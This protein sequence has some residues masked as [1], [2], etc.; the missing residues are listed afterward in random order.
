MMMKQNVATR[1]NRR[2]QRP[3]RDVSKIQGQAQAALQ[4]FIFK[5]DTFVGTELFGASRPV[6]VGRHQDAELQLDNE[7]V[8]RYHCRVS[9]VA[10]QIFAEDLDSGNGTLLNHKALRART[11]LQSSDQ[12]HVGPYTLRLKLLCAPGPRP[13]DPSKSEDTTKINALLAAERIAG[14]TNE[15]HVELAAPAFNEALYRDAIRR[16]TAGEKAHALTPIPSEKLEEDST[17]MAAEEVALIQDP[18]IIA[19]N[20]GPDVE[21]RLRDLDALI[22]S[23]EAEDRAP[24]QGMWAAENTAPTT[25]ELDIED[26]IFSRSA[27]S[28]INTREFA[29]DLASRLALGGEVAPRT[30]TIIPL[31][32]VPTPVPQSLLDDDE[33]STQAELQDVALNS[34]LL[35][36]ALLDD[37]NPETDLLEGGIPPQLIPQIIAPSVPTPIPAISERTAR[38]RDPAATGPSNVPTKGLVIPKPLPP[39]APMD[40]AATKPVAPAPHKVR[41][42][43]QARLMTPT[44][45][46]VNV[47]AMQNKAPE[48]D[49]LDNVWAQTPAPVLPP[50]LPQRRA[51]E[52][53]PQAKMD[54]YREAVQQLPD[55]PIPMHWDGIEVSARVQGQLVDI[56]VLRKAGDEY[57]L[58]HRTPQGAIAPAHVHVGLRLVRIN[59]DETVDLVFPRDVAGHLVRGDR[60]VDFLTLAEGRKYS[61]LRLEG[62]DVAAI[63][64]G[65]GRQEVTYSVRFLHRPMSLMK[66]LRTA[67]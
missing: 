48:S 17:Q 2:R 65:S 25:T 40:V 15:V 10:G 4:V 33:G 30:A 54:N 24:S 58:G 63:G 20:R 12:I 49:N 46:R 53:R 47:T 3:S 34:G 55:A 6:N 32:R 29:R 8:S 18:V 28:P 42:Q 45:Q 1:S 37:D 26:A 19:P 52:A 41:R 66:S 67:R 13:Y 36:A 39:K 16:S 38:L 56:C 7:T 31:H 9:V 5:G 60:D 35:S 59:K 62:R 51:T 21:A 57:I 14:E 50:P 44:S 61:C 27:A 64:L 11:Q 22:A 23:L 43:H